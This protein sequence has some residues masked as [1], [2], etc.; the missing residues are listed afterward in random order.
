MAPRRKNANPLALAVM[1]L[2]QERP[3]H[4][5]EM[6][7]TLR[8]R[9]MDTTFKL[10]TGTLYSTV[11]ALV[12][13]GWIQPHATVREGNRPQRT[14][15]AHTEPGEREFLAWLDSIIRTPSPEY[16]V[17]LSAVAYLGALGPDR[18]QH[19]LTQRAELLREQIE[20]ART[21]LE[22]VTADHELPRL[23]LI[24]VEYAVHMSE[25]ELAW[26]TRTLDEIR[27][28]SLSWPAAPATEAAE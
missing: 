28:G 4:P 14:V 27:T 23:F 2:L 13:D 1:G 21:D 16:P 18:A 6:A 26:V 10:S 20:S 19:A 3:M 9:H 11:E 15:Y 7:S 5:Y 17:F 12:R 8:E 24:E 25:A 22:E